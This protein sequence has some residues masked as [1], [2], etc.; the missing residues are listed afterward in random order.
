MRP[1]IAVLS[2]SP[3]G[4]AQPGTKLR[5]QSPAYTDKVA[6]ARACDLKQGNTPR[7]IHRSDFVEVHRKR[8]VTRNKTATQ[9]AE[10]FSK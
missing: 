6:P 9:V 4:E 7:Q 5:E 10:K 2:C 1:Q 3:L 8:P